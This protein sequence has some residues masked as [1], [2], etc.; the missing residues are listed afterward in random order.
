MYGQVN[1]LIMLGVIS[2]MKKWTLYAGFMLCSLLLV[3]SFSVHKTYAATVEQTD[4]GTVLSN[5]AANDRTVPTGLNNIGQWFVVPSL[6][7]N[8]ATVINANEDKN[9]SNSDVIA[10]TQLKKTHSVGAIWADRS[11]SDQDNRNYIDIDKRQ[12]MSM[13]MYFGG[14]RRSNVVAPDPGDGMAFVLQ[15]VGTKAFTTLPSNNVNVGEAVGVWGETNNK[16]DTAETIA[17]R[18]IQNSWALEFDTYP[19]GNGSG[20][21]SNFDTDLNSTYYNHIA[22][23][24]PALASTYR[25]TSNGAAMNH[26]GVQGLKLADDY[27]HHLSLIWHPASGGNSAY[28]EFHFNDK[29]L[30]GEPQTGISENI[31]IDVSNFNLT[32][33]EHK[34]YW[35]FTGSTGDSAENNLIVFESIPAMVEA[36]A[37]STIIDESAGDHILSDPTTDE[38]NS[39]VV[40]EGDSVSVN[41]DLNYVSGSKPW[42]KIAA[43]IKLPDKINYNSAVITYT[44]KS[45]NKS[46]EN[47][48][49]FNGMTNNEITHTLAKALYKDDITSANIKFEGTVNSGT[50]ATTTNVE[51]EHASFRGDVLDKDVMTTA[52]VI[53]QANKMTLTKDSSDPTIGFSA[54][55]NLQGKVSYSDTST[56]VD[57]SKLSVVAKVNDG[58]VTKIDMNTIANGATFSLPMSTDLFSDLHEG[59]NTV[60]L[61]V[62]NKD[63]YNTSNTITYTVT[64]ESTLQVKANPTSSFNS[65][66]AVKANRLISRANDWSVDV[67]DGRAKGS[68]WNLF[69]EA[70]PV[71]NGNKTWNG[72]LVYVKSGESEQSLTNNKI[73]IDNGTKSQDGQQTF[74]VD[75][76]WTK[77]TGVLLRQSSLEN[78]GT[79]HSTITWTAQDSL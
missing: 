33:G 38:P 36:D 12:T 26:K 79:Y 44:D 45:G 5:N 53:K 3:I 15:N 37:T 25:Q 57:P 7:N 68:K 23:N 65:V 60:T 21:D 22:Y 71:T 52:F 63:D 55:T 59:A 62:Y 67:I 49:E 10:L 18:A 76:S 27:W 9:K 34:L 28:I 61:Y 31:P 17:K 16:A 2:I 42:Q 75:D 29:T 74:D 51:S 43:D 69:A 4:I 47:I 46:T 58:D 66:Q 13:W 30:S 1:I 73:N 20:Q 41:Y 72:G 54:I 40:H 78:T 77:D 35:G 14:S 24:Y 50:T 32:N 48:D 8:N 6:T 19:N 39:N 11:Q 56:T 70:T 64:V